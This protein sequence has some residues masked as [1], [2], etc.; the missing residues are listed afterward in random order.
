MN[1]VALKKGIERLASR[2][3]EKFSAVYDEDLWPLLREFGLLD[4]LDAGL[5]TCAITKEPLTRDTVGGILMTP[6]GPRLVSQKVA[7]TSALTGAGR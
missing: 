5:A 4:D 3:T 2:R 1:T 7:I 6:T